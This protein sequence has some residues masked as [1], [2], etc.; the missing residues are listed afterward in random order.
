MAGPPFGI[1]ETS[2][3]DNAIISAF[4]TNER[5]NR[6][7][8]EDWLNFISDPATGLIRPGVLPA[9]TSEFA[10]GTKVLFQQTSAP[11]GWT[12]DVTHN[13]KALRL[14]NGT[15]TTGGTTAFTTVFASRTPAGTLNNVSVTGT[16]DG[17]TPSGSISSVVATGTVGGTAI[18]TANLPVHNHGATGLTFT[19]NALADHTHALTTGTQIRATGG[20]SNVQGGG[21]TTIQNAD[22]A[23]ASGG[24]PSGSI[25]GNT[26][27]TGSGTTHTHSLTMDSHSH[28]FTGNSHTHTFTATSH[29]HTFT[30]TAMDFAVQFV[31]VI[32][33]TKD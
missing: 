32:I 22:I 3:A 6:F 9:P 18:T 5:L 10:S 27:N 8:I 11:T 31:D 29:G 23:G 13:N 17:T 30:G 28:T 4:P 1:D 24:T 33:A 7:N 26:A 12:K 15:V 16:T 19:G 25:G 2:P 20:G 21:A 14:V